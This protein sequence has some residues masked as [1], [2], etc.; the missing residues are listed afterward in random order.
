VRARQL[1]R[2]DDGREQGK[3]LR[4]VAPGPLQTPGHALVCVME[5]PWVAES[6]NL[7][8]SPSISLA[9]CG[10]RYSFAVP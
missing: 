9:I 2:Q 7:L 4:K 10:A 5:P 8:V 6:Q 1:G 3:G